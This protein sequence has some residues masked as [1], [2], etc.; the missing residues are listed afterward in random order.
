MEH[1]VYGLK[2]MYI[3]IQIHIYIHIHICTVISI[4][5]WFDFFLNHEKQK[6]QNHGL[7]W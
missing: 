5:L 1:N 6:F 3:Y 4:V 2:Y 7:Q